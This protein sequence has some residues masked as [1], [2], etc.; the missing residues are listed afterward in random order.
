MV[1]KLSGDIGARLASIRKAFGG[2]QMAVVVLPTA[3]ATQMCSTG[4][5]RVGVV[6]ARFRPT[7]LSDRC[8]RCF[9]FG[10]VRRDGTRKDRGNCCWRCG[11]EG[12]RLRQ[13][14]ASSE[15][16]AFFQAILTD[17]VREIKAKP[18]AVVGM[19][20]AC[21]SGVGVE[22][23]GILNVAVMIRFLQIKLRKSG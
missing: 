19:G 3:A 20:S 22:A 16:I 17:S 2:A 6:S 5:L 10:H 21:P 15:E 8:F 7:V 18:N 1:S 12:H 11:K 4:R 23:T 14:A 13:C 9:T